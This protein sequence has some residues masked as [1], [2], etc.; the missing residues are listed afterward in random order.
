ME[1]VREERGCHGAPDCSDVSLSS[2][3][4]SMTRACR[5]K[6]VMVITEANVVEEN[7]IF[8]GFKLNM[9]IH[10]ITAV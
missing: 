10:L 3:K 2:L 4:R 8:L 9:M 6:L 1:G 7:C 5:D